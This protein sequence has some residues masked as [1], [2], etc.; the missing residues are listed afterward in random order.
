M[1]ISY[2]LGFIYTRRIACSLP[3][4]SI[5]L[6]VRLESSNW[7]GSVTTALKGVDWSLAFEFIFLR[8]Y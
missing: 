4:I 3:F 7:P 2:V 1:S 8:I 6:T 5:P